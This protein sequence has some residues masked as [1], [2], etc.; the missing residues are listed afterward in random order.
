M[1][2]EENVWLELIEKMPEGKTKE[3]CKER[4][5]E[6]IDEY[7]VPVT[8]AVITFNHAIEEALDLAVYTQAL[9]GT[10]GNLSTFAVQM[11]SI[12]AFMIEVRDATRVKQEPPPI[13]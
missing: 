5:Q 9:Y 10:P 6:G 4:M 2:E 3:M 12:A 8:R 7:G 1:S 13:H 11:L